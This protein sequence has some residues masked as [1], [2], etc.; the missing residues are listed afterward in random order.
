MIHCMAMWEG[1][2]NRWGCVISDVTC[3]IFGMGAAVCMQGCVVQLR[4]ATAAASTAVRWLNNMGKQ[5]IVS[6]H[7]MRIGVPARGV[8]GC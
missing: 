1:K 7:E 5:Q 3:V 6:G 2:R 8:S 4:A